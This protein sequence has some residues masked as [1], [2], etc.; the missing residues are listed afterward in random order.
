MH[1]L[2]FDQQDNWTQLLPLTFTRPVAALRIGIL[3]IA[4]KWD[5]YAK[6]ADILTH[7]YIAFPFLSALY[8]AN[9]PRQE[10][11]LVAGYALPNPTLWQAIL[12]LE[13]EQQLWHKDT[14]LAWRTNLEVS[15]AL[16]STFP[17]LALEDGI[18]QYDKELVLID[19]PT[20]IFA[21]NGAQIRHD[22]ALV[23]KGRISAGV[24]D[25]HTIVYG[26][27]NLFVE[28]GASIKA[29]IINAEDGPVYIGK[30][31]QI[32]EG[33]VVKGPFALCDNA[34][35]NM[36]AKI[37]GDTTI[38]PYC[39]VGGEVGN[40]VFQAFSNKGHDGFLGNSVIGA[41]CNLGAD[42]NSSNLKNNYQQVSIFSYASNSQRDT[43]RLFCGL[44]MGDHSKAGINTM[45]NTGTVVGVGCNI[46]GG[47]FPAKHLEP[48]TWGGLQD[49]YSHYKINKLI[50]TERLVMARRSLDL[51]PEYEAMMR[52]L[53]T[54]IHDH[55]KPIR[56]LGQ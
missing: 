56:D 4:D 17:R 11:L 33:S 14:P 20:D 39:K 8:P 7:G 1:L 10:K 25:P 13:P 34:V 55:A 37:K 36:S 44:I 35:V 27:E 26:A 9:T 24:T 53:H 6:Q 47:G 38:G 3:T 28:E 41:W 19:N 22:Y 54:Y 31:A 30:G 49:G 40:T 48:F 18:V 12:A 2:L 50:E 5:M 16:V 51:T 43:G 32:Q 46:F 45:F 15:D 42:T 21:L 23:T 52:F 29:S